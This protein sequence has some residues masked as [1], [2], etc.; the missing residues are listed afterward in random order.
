MFYMPSS[1]KSRTSTNTDRSNWANLEDDSPDDSGGD[2]ADRPSADVNESTHNPRPTFLF[3]HEIGPLR[4]VWADGND[5]AIA[6]NN[7]VQYPWFFSKACLSFSL[8]H[9]TF[10]QVNLANMLIHP[11]GITEIFHCMARHSFIEPA[12]EGRRLFIAFSG[13]PN[14]LAAFR[15]IASDFFILRHKL[16]QQDSRGSPDFRYLAARRWLPDHDRFIILPGDGVNCAAYA[17][18]RDFFDEGG[19]ASIM[20][21]LNE[22]YAQRGCFGVWQDMEDDS[23]GSVDPPNPDGVADCDHSDMTIFVPAVPRLNYVHSPSMYASMASISEYYGPH[24]V[25]ET[26]TPNPGMKTAIQVLDIRDETG[27]NRI[28]DVSRTNLDITSLNAPLA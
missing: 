12:E 16:F 8:P 11:V 20:D 23:E 2:S 9:G 10:Y 25:V 19:R 3:T 24:Y 28:R 6:A 14:Q 26:H 17:N 18:E 27:V 15:D 4:T 1:K 5:A 21:Y 22:G 7:A 13:E